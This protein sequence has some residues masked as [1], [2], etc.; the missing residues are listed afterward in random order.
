MS[1]SNSY[2][3]ILLDLKSYY[4][5]ATCLKI[6]TSHFMSSG[7]KTPIQCNLNEPLL[8]PLEELPP[9]LTIVDRKLYGV[10][11]LSLDS[12]LCLLSIRL[13]FSIVILTSRSALPL[14]LVCFSNNT[15]FR[16]HHYVHIFLVL[17]NYL[18]FLKL[19]LDLS[20]LH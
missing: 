16:R 11:K 10:P 9:H 6:L 5:D 2:V 17:D 20:T 3:H 15:F 7:S 8:V 18:Q 4:I 13:C 1:M 14:D 19:F 12:N